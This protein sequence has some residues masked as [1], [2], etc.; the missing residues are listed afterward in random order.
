MAIWV[1]ATLWS[2]MSTQKRLRRLINW[3]VTTNSGTELKFIGKWK[4]IEDASSLPALFLLFP[5]H[6]SWTYFGARLS[7]FCSLHFHPHDSNPHLCEYCTLRRWLK[8]NPF[9]MNNFCRNCGE[10]LFVNTHISP[11]CSFRA[12]A[13]GNQIIQVNMKG[14]LQPL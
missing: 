13:V 1:Q 12:E 7:L 4:N 2:W 9:L 10:V 14:L 8:L 11:R 6:S 5:K 3:Q